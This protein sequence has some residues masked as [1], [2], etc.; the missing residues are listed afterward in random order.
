MGIEYFCCYHSYLEIMEPLN[1]AEKGRLFTACLQ[2]SMTGEAPQLSGNERFVFPAFKS[3]IDRDNQKYSDRC[4]KNAENGKAGGRPKKQT[5]SPETEKSER[6]SEEPKKAKE[7]EKAK[8]K[9]K[10]KENTSPP[11]SPSPGETGFGAA[12]QSAFDAWLAYKEEKRQ[13]YKPTGLQSLIG[14]IRNNAKK[15]GEDAVADLIRQCMASNWQGIIF[16]RLEKQQ[17]GRQGMRGA[18]HERRAAAQNFAKDAANMEKYLQK[19]RADG[20]DPER[21]SGCSR[22]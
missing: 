21:G 18:D 12:L 13:P 14:E 1:D 6:F 22:N 9:E 16:E 10:A 8:A 5:D 15:Y 19:L 7:K 3:Q 17:Y 11:L 2:Y 20:R 4:R